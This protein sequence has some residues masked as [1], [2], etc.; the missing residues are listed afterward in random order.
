MEYLNYQDQVHHDVTDGGYDQDHIPEQQH[1]LDDDDI[2][3]AAAPKVLLVD[4]PFPGGPDNI[5][6]LHSYVEHVALP[7]WYNLE[8]CREIRYVKPI[9]HGF[10][11][12]SLGRPNGNQRW[13]WDPLK[14]SGLHDLVF[15]G[16]TTVPHALSMTLCKMWCHTPN[17]DHFSLSLSILFVFLKSEIFVVSDEIST[18]RLL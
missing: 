5:S 11:I 18:K 7:L 4:P 13:F 12:L 2:A 1:V 6:L 15:L 17:F 8:N 10:K 3:A 16:Y 14:E 9:N